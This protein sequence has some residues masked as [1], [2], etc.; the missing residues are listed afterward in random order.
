MFP[1][2]LSCTAIRTSNNSSIIVARSAKE[3]EGNF[4]KLAEI[5]DFD[6]AYPFEVLDRSAHGGVHKTA[7][8]WQTA[9]PKA[10]IA[11]LSEEW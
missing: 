7:D 11:V 1:G 8:G 9:H 6:L 2:F 5:A 4:A 3:G 10:P